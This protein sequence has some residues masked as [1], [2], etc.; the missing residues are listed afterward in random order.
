MAAADKLGMRCSGRL[1]V[2]PFPPEDSTKCTFGVGAA[3]DAW[4]C[5]GWWEGV[6]MRVGKSGNDSLQIYLPGVLE[7]DIV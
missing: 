5:D 1:T 7:F 2:R 4:W 3:V 6:V